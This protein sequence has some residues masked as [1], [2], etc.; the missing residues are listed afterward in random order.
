MMRRIQEGVWIPASSDIW[1]RE[2]GSQALDFDHLLS[3]LVNPIAHAQ[4]RR[5]VRYQDQSLK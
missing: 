3:Q 4:G 2:S 1:L 5:R